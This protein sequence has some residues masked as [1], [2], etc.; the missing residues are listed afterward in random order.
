MSLL[1]FF[2][3]AMGLGSATMVHRMVDDSYPFIR[4]DSGDDEDGCSQVADGSAEV[5]DG[6]GGDSGG[7]LCRGEAGSFLSKVVGRLIL[8]RGGAPKA[9]RVFLY[10]SERG[11]GVGRAYVDMSHGRIGC[12]FSISFL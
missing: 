3:I 8:P 4:L 9:F 10:T 12:H 7:G 1:S 5:A 2:M 11:G 6:K